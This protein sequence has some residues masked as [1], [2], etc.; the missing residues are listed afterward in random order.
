MSEEVVSNIRVNIDVSKANANL[1][2]LETKIEAFNASM[3]SG[4]LAI[5][6]NQAVLNNNF[7]NGLNATGL[8]QA[9]LVPVISTMDRFSSSLEKG[10]MSLG[11]YSRNIMSQMPAMSQVFQKEFNMM[12][13]VATDRVRK[14]QSQ[15]VSL[16]NSAGGVAQAMQITPNKAIASSAASMELAIQKNQ[17]FNKLID[18]GSTKLLN[19]G[20]NTQWAGRQLMMG[21]SL[22]LAAAGALAAKTFMDL[23]KE[24]VSF[25][26]VYGDFSTTNAETAQMS[27]QVQ[28]LAVNMTKYGLS[29]AS[30][31]ELAGKS[32][33]A[34]STGAKLIEQ[35]TEATRLAVLGDIDQAK[36]LQT[37]ISLQ[38][39]F[40]ISTADLGKTV[41]YMNA[42]ENQTVLSLDDITTAIPTVATVIH[43]LGGNVQDLAV[44]LTAM[45]EGGVQAAQGA[46]A[47]K[48]GLASIENPTAKATK[49]LEGYGINI[50][51]ITAAHTGDLM[52]TLKAFGQ[53]LDG[54]SSTDRQ[55]AL[56]NLF[57]KFQYAR[58]GAM[59]ENL[60]K[61]GSQASRAMELAGAST[62]QLATLSEQELGKTSNA[63]YVKF[64]GSLER[65]KVSIA[66]IGEIFLK[67]FVPILDGVTNVA[68]AFSN[69]PGPVK[70]T[71]AIIIGAVA[72]LGPVLIMGLGLL[73]NGIANSIKLIQFFRSKIAGI[74]GDSVSFGYLSEAESAANLATTALHGS[75]NDLTGGFRSQKVVLQELISEYTRYAAAA[76]I[77]TEVGA[78]KGVARKKMSI[79]GVVPGTGSGDH[80][81]AL[82]EPG[83][84]VV[85]KQA[86][87]KYGSVIAAMNAGTLPGFAGGLSGAHLTGSQGVS[88]DLIDWLN[89]RRGVQAGSKSVEA[90]RIS[91][92]ASDPNLSQYVRGFSSLTASLPQTINAQ[93]QHGTVSVEAFMKEWFA[94]GSRLYGSLK[95]FDKGIGTTA[96]SSEELAIFEKEL[97][98]AVA[99][100]AKNGR[101]SD[102][103][104]IAATDA[105]ISSYGTAGKGMT[106]V[107]QAAKTAA[108]TFKQ[109]NVL[110]PGSMLST[111]PGVK[112]KATG[113]ENSHYVD[114][115][116]GPLVLQRT[117]KDTGKPI[118]APGR[119]GKND[120]TVGNPAGFEA[121]RA[122]GAA[123][124]NAMIAGAKAEAQIHSPSKEA[125][126]I[127][128]AFADG[129][130]VSAEK[131]KGTAETAGKI[132]A[133]AELQGL[134]G[135]LKSI[136]AGGVDPI[137]LMTRGQ[138]TAA[139][140][141]TKPVIQRTGNVGVA[142]SENINGAMGRTGAGTFTKLLSAA[143]A[144]SL[145]LSF[146]GGSVG[147]FANKL[148]IATSALDALSIV[149]DIVKS[150]QLAAAGM[151][152][153]GSVAGGASGGL[154][155]MLKGIGPAIAGFLAPILPAAAAIAAIAAVV[156]LTVASFIV[157]NKAQEDA[158]KRMGALADAATLSDD[159]LSQLAANLGYTATPKAVL[160]STADT[161]AGQAAA[162]A[163]QKQIQDQIP[164]VQ[165][166]INDLKAAT[167]GEAQL[168]MQSYLSQMVASGAPR[169]VALA[170]VE[171]I[172]SEA[173]KRDIFVKVK[174]DLQTNMSADGKINDVAALA[175]APAKAI[176]S[177]LESSRKQLADLQA[178]LSTVRS[179]TSV[180]LGGT[181]TTE[182]DANGNLKQQ[183]VLIEKIRAQYG[184]LAAASKST[185]ELLSSEYSAGKITL[186]QYNAGVAQTE[187]SYADL[188][189]ADP[190]AGMAAIRA[191]F[192]KTNPAFDE[193]IS[194]ITDVNAL[195]GLMAAKAAGVNDVDLGNLIQ[196]LITAGKY[197]GQLA[198]RLTAAALEKAK[199]AGDVATAQ[200]TYDQV[201]KDNQAKNDAA[202]AAAAAATPTTAID[203][204]I[205]GI[206]AALDNITIKEIKIDREVPDKLRAELQKDLGSSTITVGNISVD[207]HSIAD[208]DYAMSLI[209]EQVDAIN[210]QI[211]AW[212][213]KVTKLTRTENGLK[214]Q[215]AAINH[216]VSLLNVSITEINEKYNKMIEPLQK[217]ID[218]HQHILDDLNHERDLAVRSIEDQV[219]LI[220]NK[221]LIEQ[222]AADIQIRALDAQT[223][224][225]D[226]NKQIIADQVAAIDK[227]VAALNEVAKANDIIARQQKNQLDL[228]S[229]LSSGDIGAAASVM[230]AGQ[231]QSAQD[232]LSL[233]GSGFD[234]QKTTLADQSAE[235]DKQNLALAAQ[236]DAIQA[237]LDLYTQQLKDLADAKQMIIDTYDIQ[238]N[239]QQQAIADQQ[240]QIADFNYLKTTETQ[241]YQDQIDT[242]APALRDLDQSI[243]NIE[244]QIKDI[245]DQQIQPLTDQV[246]LLTRRKALI[247]DAIDDTN[248]MITAEKLQLDNRKAY[249]DQEN[250]IAGIQKKSLDAQIAAQTVLNGLTAK[251][252]QN[253]TDAL[254]ILNDKKQAQKDY[255]D[256]YAANNA[257]GAAG[258]NLTSGNG[259]PQRYAGGPIH[260][261]T[262]NLVPGAGGQDSVDASLTPGEFVIRRAMVD[263]YGLPMLQ[264]INAGSFQSGSDVTP[265][266]NV[267]TAAWKAIKDAAKAAL[268][269]L[270]AYIGLGDAKIHDA[271]VLDWTDIADWF[272]ANIVGM[273][274]SVQQNNDAMMFNFQNAW[275]NISSMTS[276]QWAGI[277]ATLTGTWVGMQ[278]S[279]AL[280]LSKVST[281]FASTW[282]SIAANTKAFTDS[283]GTHWD[284]LK[285]KASD[286]VKF[287]INTVF[288]SLM[289]DINGAI[290]FFD[291]KSPLVPWTKAPDSFDV[292]GFTGPGG[293]YQPAGIVHANEFVIKKESTNDINR[294]YPGMLDWINKHGTLP[295]MDL[296]GYADGGQ[297]STRMSSAND[298]ANALFAQL[299]ANALTTLLKNAAPVLLSTAA[300]Y[301]QALGPVASMLTPG[302][303]AG[304]HLMPFVGNYPITQGSHEGG[305]IDYGT[306]TGTPLQAVADGIIKAADMWEYSYG[307]H[308]RIAGDDGSNQMY[309][310]MQDL[311][312]KVGQRVVAGQFIGHSD[313]S[314]NS[315]GPHLHF[316]DVFGNNGWADGGNVDIPVFDQG[317]LLKPGL[318]TVMNNTG[319]MELVQPRYNLGGGY[320]RTG[321]I[322]SNIGGDNDARVYNDYKISVAVGGSDASAD[323]IA[324][325]VMN[326]IMSS[327]DSQIRGTRVYK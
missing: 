93:M 115:P 312:V 123:E 322:N 284:D 235:L 154:I 268:D 13:Q 5:A 291:P 270:N 26:K 22:P 15:F 104:L 198:N 32:A 34:G 67:A 260:F 219:A 266:S 320:D 304:G 116:A 269:D 143:S 166:K 14:M 172:A 282:T 43:G 276:V 240:A 209:G 126:K 149:M 206:Q 49:A 280:S 120:S 90:Q 53:A 11:Q 309:A 226:A 200:S 294:Q 117:N 278:G 274:L 170:F 241:F 194:K 264:E 94:P 2:Q 169:D 75:V 201:V 327:R 256:L 189:A 234:A 144:A 187:K 157:Y 4:N 159:A 48:S 80:I 223:K 81:P 66:P 164:E 18:D 249:L 153:A 202:E 79:G 262:G 139:V 267:L 319:G 317:G 261:A 288:Q 297:V 228:A 10:Q 138:A 306:P 29:V 215:Q 111:I 44:M 196:Q 77:A 318:N 298:K 28:A 217:Q 96:A 121:A 158:T 136:S 64:T 107:A 254:K 293:K 84:T 108:S 74:R 114:T 296:E 56:E 1:T 325:A 69:L 220:E 135:G 78:L 324:N 98:Q 65:L 191:E 175:A 140:A 40:G 156:G 51:A 213:D 310:H 181:S 272:K 227:Q 155:G 141:S 305:A 326:K 248:L 148:F 246:D 321:N 210:L 295:P 237:S 221:Q 41:D 95:K 224:L 302:A 86:S 33:A 290:K 101:V 92:A 128:V 151:D 58:M 76:G 119:Y 54:L 99:A 205:S 52:G 214:D 89:S 7:Q 263:K 102:T 178:K 100:R 97:A 134:R 315:T 71:I 197:G 177:D 131:N 46:N 229:A 21:F 132:L 36:A 118:G 105:V 292:G 301:L 184:G 45:K 150:K 16:G 57:G 167:I 47:L 38:S 130:L 216:Q 152:V 145:G 245:Q 17:I 162:G 146:M 73:G 127:E 23:E 171:Q 313:N 300:S 137:N 91:Y 222:H 3:N 129:L 30:T 70:S 232:A 286:P 204:Q 176:A 281:N 133:G 68:N 250:T 199:L 182:G 231:A 236:K 323:E 55:K 50:K 103:E 289:D 283:M 203:N 299:P 179:G 212:N 211:Q 277:A 252:L 9:K 106:S 279:S 190:A 42:V 142:E 39:A 259:K 218:A 12:E 63:T 185:F 251:D 180:G 8:F 230:Q 307:H 37:V 303:H 273:T 174:L 257:S 61:E 85:T 265:D 239:A 168:E 173:G 188:A 82:L 62:T 110:V 311:A 314:G 238:S 147:D 275:L 24:M 109:A 225:N 60:T 186:E 244:A 195:M 287:V 255:N 6:K 20:K 113:N 183:S 87:D 124:V 253:E 160:N 242:Y 35:T 208:A 192:H 83:E 308:I 125:E 243:F 247:Q 72:G 163:A 161:A 19:W 271:M 193:S 27:T 165:A 112:T 88:Q 233:Q 25:Q 59:F 31:V 207:V 316:F 285:K 122:A 258:P